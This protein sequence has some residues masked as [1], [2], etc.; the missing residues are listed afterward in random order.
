M[1]SLGDPRRG[2]RNRQGD[3]GVS[4]RWFFLPSSGLVEEELVPSQPGELGGWMGE[5]GGAHS[6]TATPTTGHHFWRN[7]LKQRVL[8]QSQRPRELGTLEREMGRK[9]GSWEY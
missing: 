3:V 4:P 6:L 8:N 7:G 9:K 2:S 5:P 1:G